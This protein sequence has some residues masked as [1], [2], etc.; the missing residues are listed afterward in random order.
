MS[1]V[2]ASSLFTFESVENV[3]LRVENEDEPDGKAGRESKKGFTWPYMDCRDAIVASSFT[4]TISIPAFQSQRALTGTL[5]HI[6]FEEALVLR[7]SSL[8][9]GDDGGMLRWSRAG[10]RSGD[11]SQSWKAFLFRNNFNTLT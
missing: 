7:N 6:H 4:A 8:S 3:T 10:P 9:H 2:C 5:P 1:R 11:Q